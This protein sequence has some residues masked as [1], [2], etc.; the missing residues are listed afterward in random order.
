MRNVLITFGSSSLAQ[1]VG[2]QLQPRYNV[3]YATCEPVPSFM[4][5]RFSR[6]PTGSEASFAHQL[7]AFCLDHQVDYLLPL[8]WTEIQS[9]AEAKQLFE[10]YGI[11]V[12]CPD[13]EDLE[14]VLL[15]ERPPAQ[16]DICLLLHGEVLLGNSP[17]KN[18]L[19]GLY[20]FSDSGGQSAL[21]VV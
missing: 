5:H 15:I 17:G 16:V 9:L 13:R 6:I 3:I 7:L 19:T 18:V 21:C 14:E 8:G 12:C 11:Q 20:T 4:E 2:H 10:E 1:R